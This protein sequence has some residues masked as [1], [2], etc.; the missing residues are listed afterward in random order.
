MSDK[1]PFTGI[2]RAFRFLMVCLGIVLLVW[3]AGGIVI[4]ISMIREL[5]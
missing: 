5:P 2:D 3:A 1:G 4:L